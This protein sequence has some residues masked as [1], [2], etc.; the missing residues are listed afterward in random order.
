MIGPN[1]LKFFA[2]VIAAFAVLIVAARLGRAW[3]IAM[4]VTYTILMNLSVQMQLGLFGLPV[5][6][7]NV[8]YSAVFLAS[9]VLSEHYGRREALRA[10]RIGFGASVAVVLMTAFE[11][12]YTPLPADSAMPHLRFFFDVSRY[13][14]IVGASMLSYLLAQTIDVALYDR[15]R[16]ALG[17]NRLIWVRNNVSTLVSQAFDTVF[18]TTV[19]LAG[20]VVKTWDE[21]IGAVVFAYIVKVVAAL[22]DTPFLYLTT[23]GRLMPPGSR[24]AAATASAV[25]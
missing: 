10:V 14:R 25:A 22:L 15:L 13:P 2:H 9:D 24:R 20:T 7:G 8:L 18:F 4:I 5:T 16:R 17:A 6:G 23:W 11:L 19:G 12:W 21:W 1:E 3:L